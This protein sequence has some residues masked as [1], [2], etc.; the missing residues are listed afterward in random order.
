MPLQMITMNPTNV[1]CLLVKAEKISQHEF[2]MKQNP[3]PDLNLT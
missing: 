1:L 3:Y 2:P